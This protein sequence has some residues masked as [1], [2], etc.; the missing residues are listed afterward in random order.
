MLYQLS[1]TRVFSGAIITG[2]AG[3]LL[4]G[5]ITASGALLTRIVLPRRPA[6]PLPCMVGVGFEPT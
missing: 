3:Q 5:A 6:A 4:R 2:A 1:Y